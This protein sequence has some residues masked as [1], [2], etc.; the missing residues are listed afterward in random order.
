MISQCGWL[1]FRFSLSDRDVEFMMAERGLTVR[2]ET[3]RR[4]CDKCG[5]EYSERLRR[6]AGQLEVP[7]TWVRCT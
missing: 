6:C 4:W 7:G 3:V 1:Y 2:Y 5:R